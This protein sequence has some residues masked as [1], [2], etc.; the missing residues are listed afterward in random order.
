MPT[1]AKNMLCE[2]VRTKELA[3]DLV[4]KQAKKIQ[5][6]NLTPTQRTN[7]R[8]NLRMA[9]LSKAG[10][11]QNIIAQGGMK[12]KFA[13]IALTFSEQSYFGAIRNAR[14]LAEKF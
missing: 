12:A 11:Y 7:V 2:F 5:T 14:K 3:L 4:N 6:A 10:Y 13:Q 1:E 9:A 8:E